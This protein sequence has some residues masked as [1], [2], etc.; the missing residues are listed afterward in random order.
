MVEP[1]DEDSSGEGGVGEDVEEAKAE[2]GKDV[3]HVVQ[4]GPTHSLDVLVRS[5]LPRKWHHICTHVGPFV[6][7]LNPWA[8]PE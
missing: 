7:R 1:E 3:L 5:S 2:E 4:V 6:H 8:W